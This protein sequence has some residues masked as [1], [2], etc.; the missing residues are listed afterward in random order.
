MKKIHVTVIAVLLLSFTQVNLTRNENISEKKTSSIVE[1]A[2][3]VNTYL[4]NNASTT[5]TCSSD[6]GIYPANQDV[7]ILFSSNMTYS[8]N[9][10]FNV[11]IRNASNTA[12]ISTGIELVTL[13]PGEKK[14]IIAASCNLPPMIPCDPDQFNYIATKSFKYEIVSIT[15][16]GGPTLGGFA[17]SGNNYFVTSAAKLCTSQVG[18]GGNQGKPTGWQIDEEGNIIGGN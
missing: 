17:P 5:P 8:T 15:E 18:G 2:P 13:N 11:Y 1:T 9:I 16:L 4:L 6:S 3:F 12:W 7:E 14:G 10:L